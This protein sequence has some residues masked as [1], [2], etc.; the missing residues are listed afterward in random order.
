MSNLITISTIIFL[1]AVYNQPILNEDMFDQEEDENVCVTPSPSSA[2]IIGGHNKENIPSPPVTAQLS[3]RLPK[4]C[5]LPSSF[6]LSLS[7]S[8]EEKKSVEMLSYVLSVNHVSFII[9]SAQTLL[10]LSIKLWP[11]LY[12]TNIQSLK[13]SFP[14]MEHIG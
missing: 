14:S 6:T 4:Q 1:I 3:K 13:T 10:L 5:P 2:D 11:K 12:V 9:A 7:K 8:I